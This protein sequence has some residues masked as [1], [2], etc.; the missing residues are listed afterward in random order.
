M[1][2]LKVARIAISVPFWLLFGTKW[3]FKYA[4]TAQDVPSRLPKDLVDRFL[5]SYLKPMCSRAQRVNYAQFVR[6]RTY[7]FSTVFGEYSGLN[8]SS[9]ISVHRNGVQ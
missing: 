3:R 4:C 7:H 5:V 6:G 9:R 1:T 2:I 8:S